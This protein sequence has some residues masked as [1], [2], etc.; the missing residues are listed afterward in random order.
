MMRWERPC[1][2]LNSTTRT[3]KRRQSSTPQHSPV[4]HTASPYTASRRHFP[5]HIIGL[6]CFFFISAF[7][8]LSSCLTVDD[9]LNNTEYASYPSDITVGVYYYPWHGNDFHRGDGYLRK[10]LLPPQLPLLGEY[11]DTRPEV[12]SQHL[13]WSQ[14]ANVNLWVCSWWG[15]DRREDNTIR[16]VIL[17]HTDL[18]KNHKIALLYEGGGRGIKASAGWDTSN[19][20]PDMEYI[21]SVYFDHPNY[22]RIQ[23]K[24]VIVI[25][26][27]R[28]MHDKGVLTTVLRNMRQA[29]QDKCQTEI[30]IIGDHVWKS[31]PQGTA[32][33]AP[34]DT[35]GASLDAVTNYDV[36]GN[37]G[38]TPYATQVK[39]NQHYE[40]QRQWKSFSAGKGVGYIPGTSP[41]YNDRG[42]RLGNNN[43]GLSRRLNGRE[44]EAGTLF[45]AH[46]VQAR[47]LVSDQLGNLLLVNSWNEWHEGKLW[48]DDE[49]N[50]WVLFH[51]KS[52]LTTNSQLSQYTTQTLRLS[53]WPWIP[54]LLP[55]HPMN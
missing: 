39:I 53:P 28:Q 40:R 20:Y 47:Q 22:Y 18:N 31:P 26:L 24:P 16:S 5:F 19:V 30:F 2:P 1:L 37:V 49:W 14:R 17:K 10:Q 43:M 52:P 42:V 45:A 32:F 8:S 21:C 27:S 6:F 41:G 12:I 3:T 15:P 38:S 33:Y 4:R 54:L 23:N 36:Y 9:I 46:L 50:G 48:H 7:P 29:A 55:M 13:L 51:S 44:D 35:P 34:F 25:Y 11:D